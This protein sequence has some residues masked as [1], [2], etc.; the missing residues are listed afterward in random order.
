MDTLLRQ[1][2]F[3]K[4]TYT[5]LVDVL[6]DFAG[7]I[8]WAELSTKLYVQTPDYV[9]LPAPFCPNGTLP[10]NT[11]MQLSI[12]EHKEN[13]RH[14]TI[15]KWWMF[16]KDG[17]TDRQP[18]AIIQ[19]LCHNQ[20]RM[21]RC[22]PNRTCSAHFRYLFENMGGWQARTQSLAIKLEQLPSENQHN[23]MANLTDEQIDEGFSFMMEAPNEP[24]KQSVW[25]LKT[26]NKDTPITGWP[27]GYID[28]ILGKI[29]TEG[30]FA[31]KN[32]Q[33][34]LTLRDIQ[35]RSWMW[36]ILWY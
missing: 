12:V 1:V 9:A 8:P 36:S 14:F 7:D 28:K 34:A 27:P 18:K 26:Q 11:L 16:M 17:K 3:G 2:Q 23:F 29:A 25:V 13:P 21:I 5:T 24:V 30:C 35:E 20:P 32:Y 6:P 33:Y 19:A 22:G 4:R 31:K 10:R 15:F